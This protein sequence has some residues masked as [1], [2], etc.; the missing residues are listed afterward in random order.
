VANLL[1]DVSRELR[2]RS[3]KW[4]KGGAALERM[5]HEAAGEQTHEGVLAKVRSI[6]EGKGKTVN[7]HWVDRP[8]EEGHKY[9]VKLKTSDKGKRDT[10]TYDTPEEA[11]AA[12]HSGSHSGAAPSPPAPSPPKAPAPSPPS[13]MNFSE[14]TD[15]LRDIGQGQRI[16]I[17]GVGVTGVGNG[18]YEVQIGRTKMVYG[19]ENSAALAIQDKKHHIG[20]VKPDVLRKTIQPG[21]VAHPKELLVRVQDNAEN[22]KRMRQKVLHAS[23]IQARHTPDM[24]SKTEVTV[25]K[26][27]HGRRGR[28]LA[29]HTGSGNTLHI[30]PDVLIG[31]N[32][33]AVLEHSVN[34]G[35]WPKTD[36]EHDLATNVM[37]HEYG[38]GVH[39]MI[40]KHGIISTSRHQPNTDDPKEQEFWRGF[41]DAINHEAGGYTNAVTQPKTSDAMVTRP[42]P[43]WSDPSLPS[44]ETRFVPRMNVGAWISRNKSAISQYVSRYGSS[45]QNEM[46]AELW[47]EYVLS[48]KPRAPAKYFGDYVTD[49]LGGQG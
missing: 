45:N 27:P 31:N 38:H 14:I 2:D 9:R 47:T 6:P 37:I 12:L 3:G 42:V 28:A 44:T 40:M 36:P 21:G 13:T 15:R 20:G 25:T 8:A 23:T 22:K 17:N 26:A 33:Q 29:S 43:G 49:H 30:K 32:T 1:H 34:S 24:V 48:S 46:F 39:G 10:R 16:G 7:G 4:T 5:S 41:A 35:W 19:S 11:A 18:R